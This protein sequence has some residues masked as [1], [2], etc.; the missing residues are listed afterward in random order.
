[1]KTKLRRLLFILFIPLGVGGA[2]WIV[3]DAL[4]RRVARPVLDYPSTIDLGERD[5]G[6][7]AVGR[8][9][10]SNHGQGELQISGFATSC[11]C[12][13]V[14]REVNGRWQNVDTAVVGPGRQLELAVRVGVSAT[15]GDRQVVRVLFSCNDATQPT[16][17]INVVIPHVRGGVHSFP[18]AA[19]FGELRVG[20]T[21]RR[22][23]DLYDNRRAGRR[24]STVRSTKPDR[25]AARLVPTAPDESPPPHEQGGGWLARVEITAHTSQPG[26]LRGAI[27]VRLADEARQ[28]DVIPVFGEVVRDVECRP[29]TLILPRCVNGQLVYTGQILL[30]HRD[31][32]RF[33]LEVESLPRGITAKIRLLPDGDFRW[34]LD[35]DCAGSLPVVPGEK[36]IRLR[37]RSRGD[38]KLL[39]VPILM[40]IEP[41]SQ[42][43]QDK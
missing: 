2:T 39:N 37:V 43:Q 7:V 8:F 30:R 16:G 3:R 34:S 19:V 42:E 28:P 24:I 6:D 13:G 1:M 21:A 4:D 36:T 35:I 27:E 5:R 32:Q 17:L 12:A 15:P 22:V 40:T 9:V 38:E 10:I 14:E 25:F 26:P 31:G 23:I 18:T 33:D 11:S 41:S 29:G 20:S